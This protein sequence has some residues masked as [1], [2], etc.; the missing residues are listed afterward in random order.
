MHKG[1]TNIMVDCI[2]GQTPCSYF[3]YKAKAKAN[4]E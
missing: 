2:K 1:C 3:S 4:P